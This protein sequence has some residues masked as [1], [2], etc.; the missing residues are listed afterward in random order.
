MFS[1]W[2]NLPD[3]FR[4]LHIWQDIFDISNTELKYLQTFPYHNS[5]QWYLEYFCIQNMHIFY[6]QY[7]VPSINYIHIKLHCYEGT[8][9]ILNMGFNFHIA[10][11]SCFKSTNWYEVVFFARYQL[12]PSRQDQFRLFILNQNLWWNNLPSCSPMWEEFL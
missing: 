10:V 2:S 9:C 4:N 7:S 11:H 3:L 8:F 1:Y 12:N 5:L 6:Y